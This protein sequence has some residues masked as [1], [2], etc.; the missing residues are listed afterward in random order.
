MRPVLTV[1]LKL[2]FLVMLASFP[3]FGLALY[4]GLSAER[5]AMQQ[6]E[7]QAA[8]I[9]QDLAMRQQQIIASTRQFLATLSHLPPVRRLDAQACRPLFQEL[10]AANP[11]YGDILLSNPRGE[12]LAS[13]RIAHPTLNLSD[14][15]Y[16]DTALRTGD[17]TISG[18]RKSRITNEDV[19]VCALPVRGPSRE[20]VG[21]LSTGLRLSIF[22]QMVH[23]IQLPAG[24]T[25]YMADRQGL[26]LFNRGF[27]TSNPARYPVGQ[28]IRANI[29]DRVLKEPP[30]RPFYD[31]GADAQRRLYVL[32]HS[33][34]RQGEAPYTYVGVSLPEANILAQARTGMRNTL[35]IL[36]L[37]TLLAAAGAWMVGHIVFAQRIERLA[38][39][40]ASFAA[41]DLSARTSLPAPL[42]GSRPDEL[43]QLA[44]AVDRIGQELSLRETEREATLKRLTRTQYAVDNAGEEIFWADE[45]GRFLYVNKQAAKSLGYAQEELLKLNMFDL[46]LD[47]D[48]ERWQALLKLLCVA[49]PVSFEARHRTRTGE[50]VPKEISVSLL[51]SDGIQLVFG[52]GRD[53]RQRKRHEA[54]LRTLLDE[55]SAVTGQAFF[56][57]LTAQLVAVLGADAALLGEYRGPPPLRLHTLS[58]STEQGLLE[59]REFPLEHTPGRDI[60]DTGFLLVAEGAQQRYPQASYMTDL[61]ITS[62]L[63]VPLLG[64]DGHKIGHLSFMC[65]NAI[66]NDPMLISTLRLFAQRAAAELER[67]QNERKV[68]ASLHEKEVLLKEIHHRVKNNMQIVSSLLSLQALEVSDPVV[69]DLLAQ[70]RARILSMALVH[71]D[72]YQ[73]GNLAQVDFRHYLER[74]AE[75]LRSGM[76][77]ASE[78]SIQL[79]MDDLRLE[80]DQAIP[81]GLLCNELFTNAFKHAYPTG[82]GGSV[83]VS[84]RRDDAQVVLMVRDYGKGLPE[85]FAPD[86]G[87]TLGMQ[88]IWSLAS[89]LRGEM[90]AE[91][92]GG[93][94]FTLRLPLA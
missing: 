28:P 35:A 16:F 77:G 32:R 85:D 49:G 90:R 63:G 60:P 21:I 58:I 2:L 91:N 83:L 29:W 12:V 43:G 76:S 73:T 38:Q 13:A 70:S 5:Q 9:S 66:Q 39:V 18:Y 19:L 22:E 69:L 67:L 48:P 47:N 56:D 52:S 75:R 61:G 4:S 44:Q 59:P 71:E 6:A 50:V 3:A 10:L 11:I 23:D 1:R 46:D 82:Q 65:R 53:I 14:A 84:L 74:L 80:L 64:A 45:N 51:E 20:I 57:T 40:A 72:L 27:P 68:L 62:Y 86:K 8:H 42:L 79:D 36:G 92:D 7:V 54:V 89:Q 25:I 37:A 31:I 88:L 34:L 55:T 94:V 15:S 41:G 78:I 24:S 87:T 26:R 81:L 30:G 33:V 17:F 93:A